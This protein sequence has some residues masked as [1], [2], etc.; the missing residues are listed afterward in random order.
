MKAR[1][2]DVADA[3]GLTLAYD[4]TEVVPGGRKGAVLRRGHVIREGDI[5]TLRRI[6][7]SVVKV[8][9]LEPGEV[10]E[11]NAAL[12][13]ARLAAGPGLAVE[14]PGE[15]WADA[16][17]V[18]DGLLK[19][20][21]GRLSQV[22]AISEVLLATRFDNTPLKSGELAAR[23][24]VLGLVIPEERLAAAERIAGGRPLLQVLPFR[25]L[26]AGIVVTGR[27]VYEGRVKDAF[28]PLL[29]ERLAAYGN[30]VERVDIVPDE[31]AGVAAAVR[32]MLAEKLEL[33]LVTGGMSPDDSTPDGIRQAGAEVA[34]YGAPVS[35][36]AMSLVAYV[37][38]ATV[39][40]VPAG[41]LTGKRGLFDLILPRILAG[42]R[43]GPATAAAYGHGGLLT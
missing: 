30:E 32:A 9:E 25:R 12:R 1:T 33:I 3:A 18:H 23:A 36:G 42:E 20:D 10:H 19:V 6:G 13:L 17:A 31:V 15:A 4:L 34:F 27:E 26:M 37:G 43:L 5:E 11:D 7:K 39:V 16:R 35:P 29:R 41:L 2:I 8:F 14:M 28:G 24:K 40:G 38:E 22:N 21:V